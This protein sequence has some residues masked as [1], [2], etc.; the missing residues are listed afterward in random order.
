M[1]EN[2]GLT[3]DKT[4]IDFRRVIKSDLILSIKIA[5][6][7]Q[8]RRDI[9]WENAQDLEHIATLHPKT[10]YRFTFLDFSSPSS[11]TLGFSYEAMSF[12][13]TRKIFGFFPVNSIG[14][15]RIKEKYAISQFE[16][17]PLLKII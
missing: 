7:S 6:E 4:K 17:N 12:L 13:T 10:N 15:R 9:V 2:V 16:Y 5:N 1:S 3:A 8:Y 11:P 14:V